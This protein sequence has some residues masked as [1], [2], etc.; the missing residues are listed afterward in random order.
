[1]EKRIKKQKIEK[2][3]KIQLLVLTLIFLN[4]IVVFLAVQASAPATIQI[5]IKPQFTVG[6]EVLFNYT[7]TSTVDEQIEYIVSVDCPKAPLPLLEIKNVQ[8]EKDVPFKEEYVYAVVTDDIEPQT[9]RAIVSIIEPFEVSSEQNFEIVS[10]L[11]FE[12]NLLLCEDLFCTKKSKTFIQNQY[13]YLNYESNI[14]DLVV[15]ATL[16]LPDNSKQEIILPMSLAAT[17]IGAYNLEATAFKQGYKTITKKE[18]F[19]VIG[20]RAYIPL[21]QVCNVNGI[22]DNGETPQNCPQ[23]CVYI[24]TKA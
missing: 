12:F 22:C 5:D 7:F 21:I 2:S 24:P 18:Q 16:T 19:G 23:D 14:N 9:C 6:E 17:Q 11:G 20:K 15:T 13:I 10:T 8:L 4:L 3:K 1:M